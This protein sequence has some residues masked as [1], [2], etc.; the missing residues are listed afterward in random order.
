MTSRKRAGISVPSA[1]KRWRPIIRIALIVWKHG[2]EELQGKLDEIDSRIDE[3]EEVI[4]ATNDS[5][6][7]VRDTMDDAKDQMND[8]QEAAEDAKAADADAAEAQ[9]DLGEQWDKAMEGL[10]QM[11]QKG[12]KRYPTPWNMWTL[13]ASVRM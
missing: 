4:E 3:I 11:L 5:M 12:R 7:E 9:F 6:D 2:L 8:A 10:N 13:K 1:G